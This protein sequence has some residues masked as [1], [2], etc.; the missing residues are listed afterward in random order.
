MPSNFLD[1]L[2][3]AVAKIPPGPEPPP[4]GLTTKP[5]AEEAATSPNANSQKLDSPQTEKKPR[6]SVATVLPDVTGVNSILALSSGIV[7]HPTELR[8]PTERDTPQSGAVQGVA[9]GEKSNLDERPLSETHAALPVDPDVPITSIHTFSVADTKALPNQSPLASGGWSAPVNAAVAEKLTAPKQEL[10]SL[11][12]PISNPA[13][14]TEPV[15][16][17]LAGPVGETSRG[18]FGAKKGVAAQNE[19]AAVKDSAIPTPGL[20]MASHP[21]GGQDAAGQRSHSQNNPGKSGELANLQSLDKTGKVSDVVAKFETLMAARPKNGVTVELA[22]KELGSITFT[23]KSFGKSVDTQ[24]SASNSDVR[25]ALS[26]SRP[27][28]AHSMSSRGFTVSAMSVD[29]QNSGSNGGHGQSNP[30]QERGP[31][32]SFFTDFLPQ[33]ANAIPSPTR[34]QASGVDLWI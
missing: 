13:A 23:L 19:I 1:L 18:G 28:L 30:N 12:P 22:P 14:A 33:G 15:P 10:T 3:P 21:G 16:T 9:Q 32:R 25:Q 27:D 8:P 31:Q 7:V 26:D 20:A 11:V 24:F 29:G 17:L 6:N 34:V 5:E 2:F 4:T